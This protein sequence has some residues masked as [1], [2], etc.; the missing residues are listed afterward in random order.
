MREQAKQGVV[1]R[2]DH[3]CDQS[4]RD[5]EDQRIELQMRCSFGRRLAGLVVV[6][7]VRLERNVDAIGQQERQEK[8]CRHPQDEWRQE[9]RIEEEEDIRAV[10][11][12]LAIRGVLDGW[13]VVERLPWEDV[14]AETIPFNKH[15][16]RGDRV[17]AAKLVTHAV[18]V[19]RDVGSLVEFGEGSAHPNLLTVERVCDHGG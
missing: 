9:A 8:R 12:S 1:L 10:D 11:G 13:D 6:A 7:G 2:I 15:T 17:G 5:I 19:L 18:D 4:L 14:L 3:V 16:D